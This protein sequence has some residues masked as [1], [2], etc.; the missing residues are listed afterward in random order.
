MSYV[1]CKVLDHLFLPQS[2]TVIH[3]IDAAMLSGSTAHDKEATLYLLIKY[4]YIRR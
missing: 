2:T 1:S 4:M 3:Y